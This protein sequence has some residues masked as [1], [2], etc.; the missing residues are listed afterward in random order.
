MRKWSSPVAFHRAAIEGRDHSLANAI[1]MTQEL[2]LEC[3][4][5]ETVSK[6]LPQLT[7]RLRVVGRDARRADVHEQAESVIKPYRHVEGLE[8]ISSYPI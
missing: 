7:P 8:H 6:Q 2:E 1:S 4:L 5:G 3:G